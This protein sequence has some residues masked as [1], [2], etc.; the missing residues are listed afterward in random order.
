MTIEQNIFSKLEPHAKRIQDGNGND[1][2]YLPAVLLQLIE[3]KKRLATQL[4]DTAKL[5]DSLKSASV[6]AGLQTKEQVAAFNSATQS[7]IQQL[8]T[9]LQ[10]AQIRFQTSQ[11]STR[12]EISELSKS[13]ALLA[14]QTNEGF[15]AIGS[16]IKS[17]ANDAHQ[18][19]V[20]LVRFL[21]VGL[22]ASTVIVGLAI[23]ILQRH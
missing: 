21:I 22:V 2:D 17:F 4:E 11:S 13:H 18:S 1:F 6:A 20:K 14:V 5:L 16:Q 12:E 3:G 10:D 8:E 23:A 9:A 15:S 7:K 19:H